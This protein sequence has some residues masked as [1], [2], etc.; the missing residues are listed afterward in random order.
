MC[1]A[2]PG[3]GSTV[4]RHI[5][6]MDV[7]GLISRFADDTKFADSGNREGGCLRVQHGLDQLE[8]RAKEW[9]MKFNLCKGKVINLGS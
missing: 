6:D 9:Q 1:A 7:V 2:E 5:N 3:A 4:V 8:K